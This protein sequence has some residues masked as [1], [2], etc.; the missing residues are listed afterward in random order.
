MQMA[1]ENEFVIPSAANGQQ[2]ELTIKHIRSI[3]LDQSSTMRGEM[4]QKVLQ[5]LNVMIRQ[6]LRAQNFK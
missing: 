5:F 1:E 3:N 2:V 4:A 6:V